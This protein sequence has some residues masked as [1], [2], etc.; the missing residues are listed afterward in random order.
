MV[1]VAGPRTVAGILLRAFGRPVPAALTGI[2]EGVGRARG[3]DTIAG[4]RR[5]ADTSAATL[6]ADGE[7]DVRRAGRAGTVAEL[8]HVTRVCGRVALR[9]DQLER[10]SGCAAGTAVA[11]LACV[12]IEVAAY[13]TRGVGSDLFE[14]RA[15]PDFVEPRLVAV[16]RGLQPDEAEFELLDAGEI[17]VGGS[18]TGLAI[19]HGVDPQPR[20][21]VAAREIDTHHQEMQV[22]GTEGNGCQAGITVRISKPQAVAVRVLGALPKEKAVAEPNIVDSGCVV[23]VDERTG[24]HGA[25]VDRGVDGAIDAVDGARGAALA[26]A[27]AG[28]RE[29]VAG[30]IRVRETGARDPD[31]AGAGPRILPVPGPTVF[32]GQLAR[33]VDEPVVGLRHA[34]RGR[35]AREHEAEQESQCGDPSPVLGGIES[36]PELPGIEKTEQIRHHSL[37]FAE[38]YPK[39]PLQ[40]AHT[41]YDTEPRGK[42]YY[43]NI[44][45]SPQRRAK[46]SQS[47]PQ[48]AGFMLG[49]R[50]AHGPKG[51]KDRRQGPVK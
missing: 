33:S 13:G 2:R 40:A 11:V 10:T 45:Y 47:P 26:D 34:L 6:G 42:S 15:E 21:L 44:G 41:T 20:L 8:G 27:V 16:P 29:F 31:L 19:E 50:P 22:V 3:G 48:F 30:G 51:R 5:V 38:N 14:G 23:T 1:R 7:D 4:L 17:R 18:S 25:G 49:S 36:R 46:S 39:R 43:F 24:P 12:N 35:G 37:Q 28:N 9:R 32:T